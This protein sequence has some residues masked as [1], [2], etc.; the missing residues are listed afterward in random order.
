MIWMWYV[1]MQ[2]SAWWCCACAGYVRYADEDASNETRSQVMLR[3]ENEVKRREREEER[4]E[5]RD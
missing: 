5:K 1:C 4:K 2:E 3:D